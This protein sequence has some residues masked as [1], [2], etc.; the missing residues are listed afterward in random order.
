MVWL[1][2]G[3]VYKP[4]VYCVTFTTYNVD[5]SSLHSLTRNRPVSNDTVTSSIG[6]R[7]HPAMMTSSLRLDDVEYAEH[8]RSTDAD[9]DTQIHRACL[10]RVD[11]VWNEQLDDNN[12]DR[13][14]RVLNVGYRPLRETGSTVNETRIDGD[15]RTYR[16]LRRRE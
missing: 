10:Q 1:P 6:S 13:R 11:D 5:E 2:L 8:A 9:S 14:W 4:G 15:G 3:A 16:L 7:R 12:V